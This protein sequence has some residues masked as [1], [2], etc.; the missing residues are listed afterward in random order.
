MKC[1]TDEAG[2]PK[3]EA[4][5][6]MK[7]SVDCRNLEYSAKFRWSIDLCGLKAH[8]LLSVREKILTRQPFLIRIFETFIIIQEEKSTKYKKRNGVL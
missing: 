2:V 3:D 8:N 1:P 6:M 7:G 4:D 5:A